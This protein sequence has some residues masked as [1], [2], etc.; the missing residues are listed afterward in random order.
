[1]HTAQSMHSGTCMPGHGILQ[2]ASH[3][4]QYLPLPADV[5]YTQEPGCAHGLRD[6]ALPCLPVRPARPVPS[7]AVLITCRNLGVLTA[8]VMQPS[9]DDS[10]ALQRVSPQR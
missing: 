7:P 5:D 2:D 10:W 1:M 9:G 6:S 3:A 4:V 8:R